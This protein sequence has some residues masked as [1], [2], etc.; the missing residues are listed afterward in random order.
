MRGS[1]SLLLAVATSLSSACARPQ[2]DAIALADLIADAA[3]SLRR[4]G[5]SLTQTV[6][7]QFK[8]DASLLVALVPATG[9]NAETL[10]ADASDV[11]RTG[12]RNAA[13]MWPNQEVLAITWQDG[14]SSGPDIER[15][16]DIPRQLAVVKPPRG[17]VVVVLT[18]ESDGRIVVSDLK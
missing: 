8:R 3:Q 5:A 9:L 11:Q 16:V 6:E 1:L 2:E 4:S 13:S 10:P 12:M 7:Y 18:R 15:H 14:T 17:R